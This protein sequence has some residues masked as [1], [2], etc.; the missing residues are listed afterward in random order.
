MHLVFLS[1]FLT[2]HQIAF[3]QHMYTRFGAGFCFVATESFQSKTVSTGYSDLNSEY[4][5]V[6]RAYESTMQKEKAQHLTD[7]ADVVI[8]GGAPFDYVMPRLS[9]GKLTFLYSERL[10]KSGYQA[11]KLPVRLL[12][13]WKKYGRHKSLYLLCASAYTA[14]DFAKTGTFLRKAYNWG[15]FPETKQYPDTHSLLSQKTPQSI[16]WAGRFLDWKHPEHVVEV[17]RRLKADGYDFHIKMLGSGELW[18][19]TAQRVK[20]LGLEEQV[21]LPG[22]IP[23]EDVRA[24]MEQASIYLFTSDRNEG[25]GAV[26]NESMNSGCAVV[27]G[28][29]IGAVPFLLKDGENG[30][31]YADGNVNDLYAKVKYLLDHPQTCADMGMAAYK[32]ITG[33]WNADVAAERFLSLCDLLLHGEKHPFPYESGPCSEAKIIKENE[34]IL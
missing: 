27:A 33:E 28:S 11:W 24:Y 3:C 29:A 1:N 17:A 6:L 31:I 14:A 20:E 30:M 22:A 34:C 4:P 32:T 21:F 26:L 10:Y 18:D 16:L 25:W 7:V 23:A 5:F 8:L 19:A 2:P 12:R 15:Y 13:F 9:A